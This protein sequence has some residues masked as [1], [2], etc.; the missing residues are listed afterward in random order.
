MYVVK[1]LVLS[2]DQKSAIYKIIYTST[3][4]N[5]ICEHV[6]QRAHSMV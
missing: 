4:L 6:E 1:G 3:R 2:N 5:M